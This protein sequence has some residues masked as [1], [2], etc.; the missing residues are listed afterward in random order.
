V[1]D[2]CRFIDGFCCYCCFECLMFAN[3]LMD[4]VVV[5]SVLCLQIS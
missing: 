1:F 2:V 5:W 4:F 3:S